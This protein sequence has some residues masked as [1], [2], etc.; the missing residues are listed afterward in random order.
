MKGKLSGTD[1]D[2]GLVVFGN[3]HAEDEKEAIAEAKGHFKNKPVFTMPDDFTSE[4][5][6][7]KNVHPIFLVREDGKD[8]LAAIIS[9]TYD[10]KRGKRF[11]GIKEL[12]PRYPLR[13]FR[14][15]PLQE[16]LAIRARDVLVGKSGGVL[17]LIAAVVAIIVGVH[18]FS[19]P[20]TSPGTLDNPPVPPVF[21]KTPVPLPQP[22][23]AAPLTDMQK[24]LQAYLVQQL[25][26]EISSRG[27]R[28]L[29]LA[30]TKPP[31]YRP[32][33]G[34]ATCT[35]DAGIEAS[36][37]TILASSEHKATETGDTAD[38]TIQKACRRAV[39]DMV[40]DYRSQ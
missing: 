19:G 3:L 22:H 24:V 9:R 32:G 16:P 13:I 31:L 37:H 7:L 17:T 36:G 28:N 29:S 26:P 21:R 27:L 2:D 40:S 39:D 23:P 34:T 10:L 6:S 4:Q 11:S 15:L 25:A 5:A 35:I 8:Y 1:I 33:N 20:S 18:T 14:Q 30:F 38:E 12:D